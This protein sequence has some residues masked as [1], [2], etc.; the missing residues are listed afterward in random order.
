[1]LVFLPLLEECFYRAM[2][3]DGLTNLGLPLVVCV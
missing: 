3:F 1:M 2:L